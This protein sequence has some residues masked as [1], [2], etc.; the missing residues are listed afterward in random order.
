MMGNAKVSCY[1]DYLCFLY[2]L[3][4]RG[5]YF[6][7]V[8][9][10]RSTPSPPSVSFPHYI[11]LVKRVWGE[12]KIIIYRGTPA[13][14]FLGGVLTSFFKHFGGREWRVASDCVKFLWRMKRKTDCL[15]EN[16]QGNGFHTH[17][18][19]LYSFCAGGLCPP[20]SPTRALP[21]TRKGV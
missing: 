16:V 9:W 11:G 10:V 8:S 13:P 17:F 6:G 18:Q 5:W 19:T 2:Y 12:R 7:V 14:I 15:E 3:G 1:F 21:L 4:I 20:G